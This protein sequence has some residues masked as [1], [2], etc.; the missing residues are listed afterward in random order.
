MRLVALLLSILLIVPA[1]AAEASILDI[2]QGVAKETAKPKAKPAPRR[3]PATRRPIVLPP[4]EGTKVKGRPL[5]VIDPGHGGHDPGAPSADG[6]RREKEAALAIGRAIRDELVRS[7]RVRVALTRDS[8]TFLVLGD[9]R[10]IARRLGADLF[11]SIHADSAPSATAHGATIYTLSDV[12]SDR[13][14]AQ[15]AAKENRA[16]ILNGVDLGG[17]N[18]DVSSIL[19]DLAQRETMNISSVFA[20]LLQRELSPLINFR[21]TFHK[22]AGFVVLKAPDVP[23]LLLETGYMSNA[24]DEALLFSKDY[25]KK[26]ATGIRRAVEVHFARRLAGA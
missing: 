24:E 16:D 8:D 12:S 4:I 5:V 20:N 13:V 25:Q 23:S 15:L 7:G 14:A 26:I 21:S 2:L 1:V 11:I 6:K 22:F 10:E 18:D 19:V 9:R 3:V 17:E